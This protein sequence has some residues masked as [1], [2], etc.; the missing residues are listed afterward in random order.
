[1]VVIGFPSDQF[2]GQ[3]PETNEFIV[4]VCQLNFGVTFQLTEKI[5]V[6]GKDTHLVFKYLKEESS[7]SKLEQKIKWIF[8]KFLIDKNGNLIKRYS[9]KTSP[10]DIEK[11]II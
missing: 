6:N 11:L 1:M 4:N 2:L 5:N 7:K 10:F 3:E 8:T 9:P